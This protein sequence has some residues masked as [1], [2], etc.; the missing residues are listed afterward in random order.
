M[1]LPTFDSVALLSRA[2]R[3]LP[4][5]QRVRVR[6]ETLP[7]V[8][9]QFVQP[10][11]TAEREIVVRGVLEAAG[12]SAAEAHQAL[13]SELRGRQALADGATIAEYVGTDGSQYSNCMLTSYEATE[14]AKVS[15]LSQS[16]FKAFV[17]IEARILHL[18]P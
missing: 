12:A 3:D 14:E 16:S 10:H 7:G 17:P 4:S 18:T 11:G 13:K 8:N 2:A 1:P 6:G 9:G 15:R 5:C